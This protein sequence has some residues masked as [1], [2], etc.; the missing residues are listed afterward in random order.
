MNIIPLMHCTNMETSVSFYI[1][2]LDFE[3]AGTWP[4]LGD[5]AFSILTRAGAELHLSSHGADGRTGSTASVIVTDI[6]TLF[7]K[8]ISRGLDTSFKKDS[9]V[10]Q[11]PLDQTWG[12]REFYVNDPDG[13]TLCFVQR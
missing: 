9:P 3:L 6:D 13:N 7:K 10:H 12:T 1:N 8:Y 4:E 11:A 5:P 2:I